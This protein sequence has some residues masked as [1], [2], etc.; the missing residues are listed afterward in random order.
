VVGVQWQ[1]MTAAWEH[2]PF[3]LAVQQ[4]LPRTKP[5][6]VAKQARLSVFRV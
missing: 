4:A 5:G 3:V 2:F 1:A 6:P